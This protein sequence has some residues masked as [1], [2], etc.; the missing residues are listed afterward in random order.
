MQPITQ[1]SF[2]HLLS[3]LADYANKQGYDAVERHLQQALT[4]YHL[5]QKNPITIEVSSLEAFNE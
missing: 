4:R 2:E 5:T 3:S 1:D